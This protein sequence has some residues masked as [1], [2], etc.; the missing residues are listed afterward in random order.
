LING[1]NSAMMGM[2]QAI[3]E[4][5]RGEY[6]LLCGVCG[7]IGPDRLGIRFT[8]QEDGVVVGQFDGKDHHQG[9]NGYLHGGLIATLLDSAMTNCLFAQG[10]VALTAELS[11]R[12]LKPV[13]VGV[14][15]VVS[16]WVE[17]LASP[18]F[19]MNGKICQN[20]EIMAKATAKFM[21][22]R[23]GSAIESSL[24]K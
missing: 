1:Q 23:P 5:T 24:C 17:G 4:K 16:A 8:V 3:L 15:S 22:I 13:L 19:K 10:R 2:S 21:E 6:H 20:D 9:Y 12:F 11:I 14:P 7:R 18:L